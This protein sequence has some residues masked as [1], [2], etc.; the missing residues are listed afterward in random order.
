[1]TPV[2]SPP[3]H[4]GFTELQTGSLIRLEDWVALLYMQ[5]M[6][7]AQ[8]FAIHD[9]C[10]C[11]SFFALSRLCALS[12]VCLSVVLNA[13][14]ITSMAW[15]RLYAGFTQFHTQQEHSWRTLALCYMKEACGTYMH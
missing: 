15:N 13:C 11:F 10:R 12:C 8:V 1:M 3:V 6:T 9:K 4:Y 5:E 7:D 2:P 14:V